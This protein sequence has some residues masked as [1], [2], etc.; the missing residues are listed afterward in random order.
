[1]EMLWLRHLEVLLGGFRAV[2][3]LLLTVMLVSLGIGAV[4][5]GW[6]DRRFGQP[7]RTLMIVQAVF[8]IAT[9]TGLAAST[10]EGLSVQGASLATSL[11]TL[12]P[13]ARAI[14]ELWFNLRPMWLEVALPSLVSGLAFPLAN[15]VV[16]RARESVGRRAGMLYAANT[17]GAVCGSLV[18][19]FL[20]LPRLGMQHS[21]G[22]LAGI[23]VLAIVPL[24]LVS[25]EDAPRPV[26]TLAGTSL[27]GTCGLLLWL[28][29][30]GD[31]MI[32]RALAHDA[33]GEGVL[34]LREGVT[35]L[36]AVVDHPRRGRGLLTNGH[37]MSSTARLDQRYMRA[38]AHIPLLSM[39]APERVLVIGFGVGN[40]THAAALHSSV[41]RV[42]VADLSRYIMEQGGYFS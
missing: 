15:A 7:A 21:A 25:R 12:S 8:A 23:A 36:V 40:T 29:L 41:T 42:E 14:A 31:F 30:P 18:T 33:R 17:F 22:V 28:L 26:V 4:I 34:T 39:N 3:S 38:L 20:L 13:S 1:M 35:E 5:G 11:G 6:L 24:F 19:G 9:L 10:A 27:V 16:Q 32:E 37:A 2:L